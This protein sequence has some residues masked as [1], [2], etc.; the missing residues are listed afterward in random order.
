MSFFCLLKTPFM[1]VRIMKKIRLVPLQA[2]IP[3]SNEADRKRAFL[4]ASAS[5]TAE[6]AIA[7]PLMLFAGVL[8]LMPIRILDVERQMQAIVNSA[9]ETISQMAYLAGEEGKAGSAY[10]AFLYGEGAV[11]L[12]AGELPIEGLSLAG[13]RL[14]DDGE[15]VNLMVTYR[16]KLPFSVFGL[17]AVRRTNG[18]FLRAWIGGGKAGGDEKDEEEDPIVYVGRRSTRYHAS[19]ACHYLDNRLTPVQADEIEQ[20]RNEGGG[21]YTACGR[22]GSLSGGVVY[23]MPSGEHYHSSRNCSAILAYVSAVRRSSVAHL[24]PC[25]YCWG[26]RG[27]GGW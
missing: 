19:A 8:L 6:A 25:S 10:E 14:L 16:I 15:T 3:F 7:L 12:K 2:R 20:Y 27:D 17:G 22:C 4:F 13:S 21:R 23:I 26:K 9:G 5:M 11:R 1:K 18:C 24:G